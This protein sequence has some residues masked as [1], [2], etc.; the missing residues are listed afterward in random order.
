MHAIAPVVLI[1]G[2]S[3]GIG[4]ETAQLFADDGFRVFGTS[5]HP[6]A[7]V[8]GIEPALSPNS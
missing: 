8:E 6:S 4:T 3:S 7:N 5:R 1:T 2:A